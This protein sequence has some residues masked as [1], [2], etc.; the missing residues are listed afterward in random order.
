MIDLR[1][2]TVTKP[3]QAMRQA[4]AIAEV[5]DDVYGEDPTV[6]RL[7]EVGAALVG[8]AVALFVPS[9]TMANQL[10]LRAQTQ[11]G[12]E[13]IVDSQAHMVRYEQGAGGALAGV[14][15]HW[16]AGTRGILA[17]EQVEAAIR[18]KDAHTIQTALICLENTHNSGGGAVYPLVTVERIGAIARQ[19]GLPL[20]MDGARL[21][22]A[23][24][25][26]GTSTT[27]YAKHCTTVS[28]CLSKGLGAPAG[29][30]LATND[31][32]MIDRLRRF[33]RMYGGSMRQAGILAAAG[34]YALEHNISRLKDD[35][36][37][38]KRLATLLAQIPTVTIDVK[39]VQTNIVFFDVATS[40]TPAELVAALKAEG[41]AVNA[42][43]GRT[44]RAV[45]HLDLSADDIEKAGGIF[46]RVLSR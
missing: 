8:K 32:D 4:M 41:I 20:H 22:N 2:D 33:R 11:P 39:T 14:Q 28:F 19:R 7:Q 44:Y 46:A 23:V 5:G 16:V 40:H 26:T 35:H 42:V 1:S 25:A 29:S 17:P 34:L 31:R 15:F 9:G 43:G 6:N 45:T 36:D 12:Q 27:E 37:N 18:P 3:S 13:V 38:A 30:L 24:V 10:A 21:F